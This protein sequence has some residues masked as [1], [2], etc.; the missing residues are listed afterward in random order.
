MPRCCLLGILFALCVRAEIIDRIAVTVGKQVIAASEII[1]DVRISA[2]LDRKPISLASD[3]KR[4]AAERLVDQIL[5]LR[6]AAESRVTLP[7]EPEAA[8]LLVQV[9]SQYGTD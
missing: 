9:K 5:I 6:E 4:K 1:R 3:I 8:R 2:F 7:D